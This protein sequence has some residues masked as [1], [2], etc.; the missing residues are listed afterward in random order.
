MYRPEI[1]Q[2]QAGLAATDA[3]IRVARAD[4]YPQAVF[5][6]TLSASGASNR[7]RQPNPYISDGFRRTS[8]RTGVGVILKTETFDRHVA[9]VAQA[10]AQHASAGHLAVAAEQLVFGRGRNRHGVG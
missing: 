5:G 3:L 2:A 4:Y 10:Q 6:L 8:A 9:R 1:L 7:F